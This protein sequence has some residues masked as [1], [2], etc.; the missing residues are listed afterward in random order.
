MDDMLVQMLE[1]NAAAARVAR[2]F[3]VLAAT[4]VTGFG[5]V[6]HLLEMLDASGVSARLSLS[7]IPLLDG[8]AELN[9]AGFRSSLDVANRRTESRLRVVDSD[10]KGQAGISRDVRSSNVGRIADRHRKGPG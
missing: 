5:L 8:F 3:G 2:E 1:S 4:D 10:C 6:G 7:A 9:I